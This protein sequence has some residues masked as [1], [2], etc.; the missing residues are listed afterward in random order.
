MKSHPAAIAAKPAVLVALACSLVPPV[1]A[2]KASPRPPNDVDPAR[3]RFEETSRREMQLRGLGASG[4]PTDPKQL[5]ALMAQ[6]QEDFE[7]ILTLHNQIV[8]AVKTAATLDN[9]FVSTASGEIKKRASRLQTA[10]AFD[11][12]DAGEQNRPKPAKFSDAQMK[13]ALIA[14]CQH[15]ESFIKNPVI[16]NPGTVDA[17]Q[18]ASARRELRSIIELGDSIYKSAERLKKSS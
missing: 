9:D 13:D 16:E 11:K 10:L 1:L 17:S 4:K 7:R 8:R 2:Q 14:L 6:V 3:A 5:Q 12:P 15:I 18:S